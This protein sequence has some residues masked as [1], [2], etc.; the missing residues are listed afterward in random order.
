MS[1]RGRPLTSIPPSSWEWSC[2]STWGCRGEKRPRPDFPPR[3]MCWKSWRRIIRWWRRYW[4]TASLQSWNP[5][6]P[7]D[8]P[9]L[10]GRTE[11]STENSTRRSLLPDGSAARIRTSRISRSG[12]SWGGWSGRYLCRR[13]AVSL[14]MRIIP[15]SNCGSW[16]IAPGTRSWSRHTGRHRISTGPR[17]PRCFMC[18][19]RKWRTCSGA[20]P[21][22]WTSGSCMGSVP[23]GSA[24]T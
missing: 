9:I 3:R 19:L 12:W 11:G 14:W 5:P 7:T 24:R 2:L 6:M 4:S 20:M 18:P 23:S 1:W 10:S 8:W 16:H 22:Q 17:H 21:R 13:R 15:R